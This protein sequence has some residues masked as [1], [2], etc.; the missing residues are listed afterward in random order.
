MPEL[1]RAEI[2]CTE[3]AP[4]KSIEMTHYWRNA[5]PSPAMS[6][7]MVGVF[8]RCGDVGFFNPDGGAWFGGGSG[9]PFATYYCPSIPT[10]MWAGGKVYET[11]VSASVPPDATDGVYDVLVAMYDR[12]ARIGL[13]PANEKT[14]SPIESF[15]SYKIGSIKVDKA[16]VSQVPATWSFAPFDP[17]KLSTV[18]PEPI[19]RSVSRRSPD[20]LA[21]WSK[22][23]ILVGTRKLG[24][25]LDKQCNYALAGVWVDGVMFESGGRF[26]A[27]GIFDAKCNRSQMFPD[28]PRWKVRAR[29][30]S[31]GVKVV[32]KRDGFE[33]VVGYRICP[34]KIEITVTPTKEEKYKALLLTG[35]GS[36]VCVPSDRDNA[37]ESSFVL[38]PSGGGAMVRFNENDRPAVSEFGQSWVYPASFVS[39]A[40][41][42]VGLIVRCPQYGGAWS[43]GTAKINGMASLLTDAAVAFRPGSHSFK[44]SRPEDH[45]TLQLVPVTDTNKDGVFN[46][47]DIG[48]AY[49]RRFIKTNAAKDFKLRDSVAGKIDID[50]QFQ[51]ARDYGELIKQ[52]R[53]IDFAPQTIWLVGAHT[54]AIGN[55]VDPPWSEYPDP[56]HN[57]LGGYDYFAFKRDAAMAGARVGIHEM[58]QYSS[59]R[60]PDWGKAPLQVDEFGGPKKEWGGIYKGEEWMACTKAMNAGLSDGSLLKGLDDHLDKWKVGSGDTWHWDCLTA[61]GGQRDYSPLHPSTNGTDIRDR[62]AVLKHFK[63]RG[64][65]MTSEGLQE[66][67]HEYCDFAW[68]AQINAGKPWGGFENSESVPLTP[69]LFQGKT[70]YCVTWHPAWNL[71]YGGKAC[72]ESV[73]LDRDALIANWFSGSVCYGLIADRTVKNMIRTDTGWR[74]N[75]FEGGSLTV[76]LANMTPAMTF[77]LEIDGR[78]YTPENPPPSP[79]G[80]SASSMKNSSDSP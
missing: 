21:T 45:V 27:V 31:D 70:Y 10:T 71:L 80:I 79:W 64:I 61:M 75:Y 22:Q 56:S 38:S 47:V 69:V 7:M 14:A 68:S 16:A 76:D 20:A 29:K 44:M 13:G 77:V 25:V 5:G 9:G 62:I 18:K 46:W 40:Y 4:G 36:L 23:P 15:T 78:K 34:D 37:V 28:D 49:R 48:V 65:H 33:M 59:K 26:P 6:Y 67:M 53:S 32:Y 55:Y 12:G 2:S 17:D 54:P 72:Y 8:F 58:F 41:N 43:Y 51:G 57:G 35:G 30:V 52:I 66:G 1:L 63:S 74:V 50:S 3:V 73:S 39:L 60:V 24:V 19:S 11:K 42:D